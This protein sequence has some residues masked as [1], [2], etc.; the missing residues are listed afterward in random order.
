M[1]VSPRVV[2]S[3]AATGSAIAQVSRCIERKQGVRFGCSRVLRYSRECNGE[4]IFSDLWFAY[5]ALRKTAGLLTSRGTMEEM[6]VLYSSASVH[7]CCTSSTV[8]RAIA[9]R[10]GP[11]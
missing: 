2:E 7:H 10:P 8:D 5:S 1:S 6:N 11:V 9:S 4:P 3:D